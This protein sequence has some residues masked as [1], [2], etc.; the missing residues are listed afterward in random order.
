VAA[1]P[2]LL[3]AAESTTPLL[4]VPELKPPLTKVP[5]PLELD[6]TE[7]IVPDATVI[8]LVAVAAMSD[9]VAFG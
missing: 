5:E 9:T 1:D 2:E 6:V 4:D 8:A 7:L 3:V